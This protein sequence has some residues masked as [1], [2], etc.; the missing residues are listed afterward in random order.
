[1]NKNFLAALAGT[2]MIAVA[3][4]SSTSGNSSSG[5]P[6][7]GGG[8]APA[9]VPA[10]VAG[11]GGGAAADVCTRRPISPSRHRRDPARTPSPF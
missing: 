5:D 4:C 1:M 9:V 10:V 8:G 6:G 3:G 7:N 2:A 11:P